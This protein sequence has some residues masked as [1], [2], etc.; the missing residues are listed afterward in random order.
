[1][2]RHG[3]WNCGD[4]KHRISNAVPE[5]MNSLEAGVIANARGLHS[6]RTLR[7]RVLLFLGKLDLAL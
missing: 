6:F 7:V 3:C 5:G 2:Y 4:E 1:M